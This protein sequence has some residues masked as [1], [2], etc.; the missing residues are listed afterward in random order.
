MEEEHQIM[1]FVIQVFDFKID[2][3]NPI[4]SN[5]II[6]RYKTWSFH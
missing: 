5:I 3:K 4:K 1:V 2:L 6:I